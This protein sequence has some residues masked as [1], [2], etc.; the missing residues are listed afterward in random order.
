MVLSQIHHRGRESNSEL[1]V[2][3]ARSL[4]V[5]AEA[6]ADNRGCIS[7]GISPALLVA[8]RNRCLYF[9]S[10]EYSFEK[11]TPPPEL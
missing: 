9:C 6:E 2:Y 3:S 7:L 5:G 8:Q 1:E 4:L 11:C 10:N